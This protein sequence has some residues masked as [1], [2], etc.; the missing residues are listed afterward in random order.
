MDIKILYLTAI[1][2]IRKDI[3]LKEIVNLL[4]KNQL[5]EELIRAV[6]RENNLLPYP[7]PGSSNIVYKR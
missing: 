6:S 2:I 3:A 1:S 7:P 4:E 5:S